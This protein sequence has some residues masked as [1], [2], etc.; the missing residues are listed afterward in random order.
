MLNRLFVSNLPAT[1][2]EAD[3]RKLFTQFGYAVREVDLI[4]DRDG[5]SM[6]AVAY[7]TLSPHANRHHAIKDISGTELD[8]CALTAEAA[9]DE[10]YKRTG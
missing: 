1:A 6:R 8:G 9:P 7:V 10:A 4:P 5:G 3:L 2:T